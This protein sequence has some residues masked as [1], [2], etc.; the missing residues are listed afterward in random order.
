MRG[1]STLSSDLEPYSSDRLLRLATYASM[2]TALVLIGVKFFGWLMTGSVSVLASLVDSLMDGGASLVNLIAVRYSLRGADADHRFGHGK[3][4]SLAGL[5]QATFIAGSAL[6]LLIESVD[7]LLHPR[8]LGNLRAGIIV[9]AF[10]I[11]VTLA[12]VSVQRYV[13]RRTQS[14]AIRADALHYITDL[15]TGLSVILAL[16]LVMGFGWHGADAWFAVGIAFYIFYSAWQIARE[17]L[18]ILMDKELSEELRNHITRIATEHPQV[19]A[20]HELRTRSSGREAIIQL[21]LD[22]DPEQTL[23]EAHTIADEVEAAIRLDFPN[24]DI[25][26]H[27]DP[28]DMKR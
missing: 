22:L 12:L 11:L 4:E 18:Q 2:A 10:S 8:S 26:I 1:G 28:R 19:Y 15:L 7:R 13:I 23:R 20:V 27:Q 6:F 3:A 14:V 24:S 16:G 21:H 17:A 5:G 25:I 9:I